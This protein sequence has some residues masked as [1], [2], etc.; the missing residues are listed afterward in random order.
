MKIAALIIA[1]IV[2]STPQQ[3]FAQEAVPTTPQSDKN[4]AIKDRLSERKDILMERKGNLEDKK[5]AIQT[6]L[7]E[8]REG[9]SAAFMQKKA[10]FKVQL[11]NLTDE[12]KKA[13]A[14]KLD[15]KLET[16]NTNRTTR[17]TEK[18]TK[19]NEILAKLEEKKILAETNGQNV[20]SV[21]AAIAA[22]EQ[23]IV[24]AE[25]AIAAQ[26]A[27]DYTAQVTDE[28][29]L[30]VNFGAVVKQ[31]RADLNITHKTV[32]AAKEAVRAAAKSIKALEVTPS[33]AVIPSIAATP[34]I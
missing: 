7:I 28:S 32:I 30:K 11:E 14:E 5:Q 23:A 10:T 22:G 20:S 12:Q 13:L 3:V 17:M 2:I 29:T 18:I 6:A 4:E 34:A 33:A 1:L 27:K 25:T 24:A 21:T 31:L 19:L 16:L 8:R 9:K 26:A 15:A